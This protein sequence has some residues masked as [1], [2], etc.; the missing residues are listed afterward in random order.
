MDETETE[1]VA[2]QNKIRELTGWTHL[3]PAEGLRS[4][5]ANDYYI[6]GVPVMILLNAKTKEIIALPE[7]AEQ[8]SKLLA[9][10]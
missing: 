10:Q 7:S 9:K 6:L 4:K 3:R 8:L 1:T 5:V 2:W